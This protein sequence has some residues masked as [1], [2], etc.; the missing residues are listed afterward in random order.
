MET[1]QTRL[2]ATNHES[3]SC[4]SLAMG[5]KLWVTFENRI[6]VLVN[7]T[8]DQWP[9]GSDQPVNS[10]GFFLNVLEDKV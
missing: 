4:S 9:H 1:I 6:R 3:K 5:S 7:L 8:P 2:E 10:G